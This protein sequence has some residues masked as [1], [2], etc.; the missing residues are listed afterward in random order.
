MQQRWIAANSEGRENASGG[1]AEKKRKRNTKGKGTQ[2]SNECG[3]KTGGMDK[4]AATS[5]GTD[6]EAMMNSS[7]GRMNNTTSKSPNSTGRRT[8]D[9][10]DDIESGLFGESNQ[11]KKCST[12]SSDLILDLALLRRT[13]QTPHAN[14]SSGSAQ[15]SKSAS[16]ASTSVSASGGGASSA[17]ISALGSGPGSGTHQPGMGTGRPR[18]QYPAPIG[19]STTEIDEMMTANAARCSQPVSAQGHSYKQANRRTSGGIVLITQHKT[20]IKDIIDKRKNELTED[21][22]TLKQEMQ[23]VVRN[24][25]KVVVGIQTNRKRGSEK[26]LIPGPPEPGDPPR[27]NACGLPYMNPWFNKDV[28]F[29]DND[30]ILN[31]RNGAYLVMPRQERPPG[32]I[33][34]LGYV[35]THRGLKKLAKTTWRGFG[36]KYKA[37]V[38]VDKA[39]MMSV[40]AK[41]AKLSRHQDDVHMS[42]HWKI[43]KFDLS[44]WMNMDYMSDEDSS[45]EPDSD[46]ETDE[47]NTAIWRKQMLRYLG[48]T[49]PTENHEDVGILEIVT[50]GWRTKFCTEVLHELTCIYRQTLTLAEQQSSKYQRVYDSGCTSKKPALT[51]PFDFMINPSWWESAKQS[52]G[53]LIKEWM[54]YGD[55]EG[56]NPLLAFKALAELPRLL[57]DGDESPAS[58]EQASNESG[59]EEQQQQKEGEEDIEDIEEE[60]DGV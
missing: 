42:L 45:P 49:G 46:G 5:G 6:M 58:D 19:P 26:F 14:S 36:E 48:Y 41:N 37:Q 60:P 20:A 50:P 52:Y 23:D 7:S 53:K 55:P 59:E 12:S 34:E 44:S 43:Y 39:R 33:E 1:D 9:E 35:V 22:Q 32:E 25:L 40:N 18:P 38:D 56:F 17:S 27:L 16:A 13:M 11:A 2:K 15:S 4:Q 28:T 30:L 29:P 54:T 8:L 47:I 21:E 3:K 57:P 10:Q 51:V 24:Q 31:K